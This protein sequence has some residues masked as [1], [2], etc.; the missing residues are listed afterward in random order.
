MTKRNAE[1]E[2]LDAVKRELVAVGFPTPRVTAE[3]FEAIRS[4]KVS[5]R[6]KK[7]D[8]S[9]GLALGYVAL[10]VSNVRKQI[11]EHPPKS[12]TE[13]D[14]WLEQMRGLRYTL[15]PLV[16][17]LLKMA[18]EVFPKEKRGRRPTLTDEQKRSACAAIETNK[19]AGNT[20]R[21]A[22]RIVADSF[23]VTERTM[24]HIWQTKGLAQSHST[25]TF[26]LTPDK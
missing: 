12:D 10:M 13:L 11:R 9:G 7:L 5:K 6:A 18:H 26:T 17:K 2:I 16:G 25:R 22:I 8:P 1:R 23:K 19:R 3:M 14:K 20:T 24:R 15:R 4:G 21:Y